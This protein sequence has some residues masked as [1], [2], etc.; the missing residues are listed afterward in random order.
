MN[1]PLPP[2]VTHEVRGSIEEEV[3]ADYYS[4]RCPHGCGWYANTFTPTRA[5]HYLALHVET[6]PLRVE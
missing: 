2:N 1:D 4:V 6:C 5:N 3:Y